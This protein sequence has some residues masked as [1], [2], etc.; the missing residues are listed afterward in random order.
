MK[1]SVRM[2]RKDKKNVR[3]GDSGMTLVEVLTALVIGSIVSAAIYT[4][5]QSQV[6]GQAVQEAMLEMQQGVRA[7]LSIMEREIRT[8]GADP[9]GNAGA[10]ILLATSGQLR[11]TRDV[12]GRTVDNMQQFDG[13]TG[14]PDEDIRYAINTQGHLG[15][16]TCNPACGNLQSIIDNIDALNFVYLNRAGDVIALPVTG[17]ALN[18]IRQVQITIVARYGQSDRGMLTAVTDNNVYRNQQDDVVLSAPGDTDRRLM[19]TTTVTCRNID[20]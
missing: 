1:M 10:Q 11:F 7:A 17:D 6:K 4:V 15:R 14:D 20:F 8:A 13:D 3:F 18:D 2:K 12:V 19:M 9:T 5:H 16:D